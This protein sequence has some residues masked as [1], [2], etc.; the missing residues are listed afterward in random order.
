MEQAERFRMKYLAEVTSLG[1]VPQDYDN[2]QVEVSDVE[3]DERPQR[4]LH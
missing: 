2:D 3:E 4:L 1:G